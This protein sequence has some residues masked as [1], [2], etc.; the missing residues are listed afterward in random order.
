MRR[1]RRFRQAVQRGARLVQHLAFDPAPLAVQAVQLLRAVGGARLVVGE[2]A[3]DAEAHV[4]QAPRGVQA[5]AEDEAEVEA[6]RVAGRAAGGARAAPRGPA[7]PW[8]ARRRFSPCATRMR[9]FASS[10]TTSA[11]VPSATR[12]VRAARLGSALVFECVSISQFGPQRQHHVEHHAHA[13]DRLGREAAARLVRVDDAL[14]VGQRVA[15]QVVV[16]DQ[17]GDAEALRA[18]RRPRRWR[19]RCPR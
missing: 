10:G 6:G 19:C 7:L 9:L 12:S 4:G 16:G 5:R 15:R 18:R 17:R 11:T 2:Q 13:G 1:A 8:P 3:F 14:G